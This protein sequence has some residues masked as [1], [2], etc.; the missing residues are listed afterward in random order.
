VCPGLG[1]VCDIGGLD[2][3]LGELRGER[4]GSPLRDRTVCRDQAVWH[5]GNRIGNARIP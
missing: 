1:D 2:T 5:D 4:P 3:D